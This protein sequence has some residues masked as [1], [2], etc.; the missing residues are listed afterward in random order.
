[1][2]NMKESLIQQ[3]TEIQ[4]E[5]VYDFYESGDYK[6]YHCH[7]PPTNV[8]AFEIVLGK[9]G[10]YV[11]GDIGSLVYRV[12]RGLEFLAGND[13]EYYQH[14]KLEHIFYEQEEL[15]RE[16][17]DKYLLDILLENIQDH[18]KY[19]EAE[20]NETEEMYPGEDTEDRKSVV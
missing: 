17:L 12:A 2:K 8:Y 13:V 11:G 7:K 15:D 19:R 20:D 10:I 6:I 1:M 18:E 4:K 3:V 16:A 9:M 5:F 14:S